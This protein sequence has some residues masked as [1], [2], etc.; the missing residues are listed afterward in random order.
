MTNL[1]DPALVKRAGE[2]IGRESAAFA[3]RTQRSAEWLAQA[4][5]R[6]PDGVPM[7]WMAALQRLPPVVAVRGKGPRFWDLDENAYL[8]FNLADQSMAAGYASPPIV[9]AIKRR[10]EAGNQFLLPT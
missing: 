7:A 6:M 1:V 10:A 5:K 4:K 8:D 3:D 2:I 9:E